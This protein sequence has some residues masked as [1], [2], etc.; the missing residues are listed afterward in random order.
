[1]IFSRQ[2]LRPSHFGT[3]PLT[4]RVLPQPQTGFRVSSVASRLPVTASCKPSAVIRSSALKIPGSGGTSRP[5]FASRP[6]CCEL[7]AVN[8]KPLFIRSS[9]S[10]FNF[11]VST[12]NGFLVTPSNAT[13]A[14]FPANADSKQL[15]QELSPLDPAFTK[16]WGGG[17]PHRNSIQT[18]DPSTVQ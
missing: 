12:L 11:K 1:M 17:T 14:S 8:C 10:A 5:S 6:S 7:S 15:A 9:V 18:L 4:P 16:N 3:R 13:L 2:P